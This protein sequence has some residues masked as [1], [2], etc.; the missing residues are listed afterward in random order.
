MADIVRFDFEGRA[1]KVMRDE[2]DGLLIGLRSFCAALDADYNVWAE[3]LRIIPAY[4]VREVI[5]GQGSALAFP[6]RVVPMMGAAIITNTFAMATSKRQKTYNL[7]LTRGVD[8]LAK[9]F[10]LNPPDQLLEALGPHLRVLV[11]ETAKATKEAVELSF[12]RVGYSLHKRVEPTD[13]CK[14][15]LIKVVQLAYQ[16][17]CPCSHGPGG[18]CGKVVVRNGKILLDRDGKPVAQFDHWRIRSDNRIQVLWLLAVDCHDERGDN[19][20]AYW[21]KP[22]DRFQDQVS[23]ICGRSLLG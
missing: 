19:F 1:L 21:R 14:E 23:K 4:G 7:L 11:E 18:V 17:H 10:G 2:N 22:H 8:A 3:K 9:E 16:G 5:V 15:S 6:Y 20:D 12:A 13:P